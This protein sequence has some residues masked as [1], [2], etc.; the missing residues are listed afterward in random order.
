MSLSNERVA[1]FENRTDSVPE[2]PSNKFSP[3]V[4]RGLDV[5]MAMTGLIVLSPLFLLIAMLIKIADSG[6][7]YYAQWRVGRHG[8]PFRCLKFRTMRTDSDECLER[9]RIDH[10]TL[11]E[12]YLRTHK[13]RNDPRVTYIG[14][15]LRR[16][17]FDELPQLLNILRGEMSVVGPRPV[18]ERELA[19]FYGPVAAAYKSVRP[20]LTGLWQVSGRS[21]TTYKERVALDEWY[22][23][24]Q[25]FWI[26]VRI[27]LKTFFV[28]LTAKGAL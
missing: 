20:G 2:G 11:Y 24:N 15:F 12:E 10:P 23:R 28:V 9:W 13:L 17:S 5:I 25:S 16:T 8:E 27:I 7:V 1:Y 6:E 18:V 21:D 3:S 14:R 4:K 26:D 22:V 19:E